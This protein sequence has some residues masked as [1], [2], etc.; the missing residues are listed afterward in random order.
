MVAAIPWHIGAAS[1]LAGAVAAIA[2]TAIPAEIA[3]R[4][5]S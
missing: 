2:A 5:N 1:A 3:R 4:A